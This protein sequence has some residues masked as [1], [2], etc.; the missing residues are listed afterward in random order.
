MMCSSGIDFKGYGTFCKLLLVICILQDICLVNWIPR[1]RMSPCCLCVQV[2]G[3]AHLHVYLG[4]MD[5]HKKMR[6]IFI[7]FIIAYH[8][9][10]LVEYHKVVYLSTV[11]DTK[12]PWLLDRVKNQ[13]YL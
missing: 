11:I 2:F 4:D 1:S 12:S 8:L 9:T 3:G 6:Q 10:C 5:E 13:S 7:C